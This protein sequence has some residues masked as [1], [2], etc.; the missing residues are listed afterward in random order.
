MNKKKAFS[1]LLVMLILIISASIKDVNAA[2]AAGDFKIDMYADKSLSGGIYDIHVTVTN[3]GDDFSG[4]LRVAVRNASYESVGY[5][6]D[7][8]VPKGSEKEYTVSI[9]GNDVILSDSVSG[10]ILDKS[11]KVVGSNSFRG[12]FNN[13]SGYINTGI[14]SDRVDDLSFLDFG[15][16][17]IGLD[18][19]NKQSIKLVD[20]SANNLIDQIDNLQLLVI[21]DY[22][23][24]TLTGN[25]IS[26]IEN[27]T[28]N[29]G[30]LLLGT[31][32]SA[33]KVLSGFSSS[34]LDISYKGTTGFSFSENG[35]A[36]D[37]EFD[38][39]IIEPGYSFYSGNYGTSVCQ[40][41]MG[42]IAVS[43]YRIID[44]KDEKEKFEETFSSYFTDMISTRVTDDDAAS[45]M[46]ISIYD[47][48]NI[49]S[50]MEKPAKQSVPLLV[51]IL[52]IYVVLIGPII[53][54]ILK[55]MKKREIIWY[56]IPCISVLFVGFVFLLSFSVKVRGLIL[57]SVTV[58]DLD[59]ESEKS[60]IMG[61]N[62]KARDWS[63]TT[64][65]TFKTASV[66]G[67]GGYM[68]SKII[69]SVKTGGANKLTYYP[70]ESFD[71]GAFVYMKHSSVEGKFKVDASMD[72]DLYSN[73]NSS[74]SYLDS[75]P[76]EHMKGNVINDT[77][78]DFD[79]VI[80]C[81][82]DK[83]QLIEGLKNGE[84]SDINMDNALSRSYSDNM[85]ENIISI[86]YKT[87][88]YDESAKLA[89]ASMVYQILRNNNGGQISELTVIGVREQSG[90]T[91]KNEKSWLCC[92]STH[93][94]WY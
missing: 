47:L 73:D 2:R 52:I 88:K 90:I 43:P 68:N 77:G 34:F 36:S 45:G 74:K 70:E 29:G 3:M 54:L 19:K 50:Y 75:F 24:K 42:C 16:K 20:I 4:T 49:M 76:A 5:E 69:G 32:G 44:F 10:L 7:I 1:I 21:D 71:M 60:Y 59:S 39:A 83:Y 57:R 41:D 51:T 8:S 65:N 23:T 53:Y 64:N 11:G 12:I 17:K 56:V 22:D 62:P 30:M 85:L 46:G 28:R 66:V 6:V 14:L 15:G 38:Y 13:Y 92:Y 9:P 67:A 48:K 86:P 87:K 89:A 80:V 58:C 40:M 93:N 72:S 79:Y 84:S 35:G 55:A 81:L 33:E 27:W 37:E 31:G 61:Y 63:V 25:T 78:V 91:D 94:D 18:T 26:A 82:G